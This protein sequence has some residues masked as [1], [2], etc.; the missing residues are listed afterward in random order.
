MATDLFQGLLNLEA[1]LRRQIL[2][3]RFADDGAYSTEE[4]LKLDAY[5]IMCH[6]EIESYLEQLAL[7]IIYWS[8][9]G[10]RRDIHDK[11]SA[12]LVM[13]YRP[14]RDKIPSTKKVPADFP[15]R[16]V[17]FKSSKSHTEAVGENNGIKEKS[18]CEMFIP[19][20]LNF[21]GVNGLL[22]SELDA[23]GS[24]RGGL[25]HTSFADPRRRTIT[26]PVLASGKMRSLLQ[27]LSEFDTEL[28][29][30]IPTAAVPIPPAAAR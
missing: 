1:M 12:S 4:L 18:V 20:G 17:G 7:R 23:W 22:L 26:E 19:L 5:V 6:A 30:Q 27:L 25:V 10:M 15:I 9:D 28:V 24:A 13:Y 11:T 29:R 3:V 14:D 2:P 16:T 8:E 21:D